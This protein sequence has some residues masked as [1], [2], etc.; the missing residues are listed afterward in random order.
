MTNC[1]VKNGFGQ[2]PLPTMPGR[3][4]LFHGDVDV[5]DSMRNLREN[6][7]KSCNPS[8]KE[9]QN[10]SFSIFNDSKG[11]ETPNAVKSVETI[12]RGG[13]DTRFIKRSK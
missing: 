3:F 1:K 7:K 8:D 2:L 12:R 5:E 10:R 4:Q 6:N 13:V 9:F 11:I